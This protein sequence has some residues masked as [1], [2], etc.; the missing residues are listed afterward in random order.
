MSSHTN[1]YVIVVIN[2]N[3]GV[4][5]NKIL[6]TAEDVNTLTSSTHTL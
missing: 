6:S 2:S 3:T 1:G 5:S 4:E